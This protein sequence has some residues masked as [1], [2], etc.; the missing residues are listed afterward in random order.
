MRTRRKSL[1]DLQNVRK[2]GG[3]AY[4][5]EEEQEQCPYAL[6]TIAETSKTRQMLEENEMEFLRKIN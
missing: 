6:K 3:T 2:E 5:K 1:S 4:N